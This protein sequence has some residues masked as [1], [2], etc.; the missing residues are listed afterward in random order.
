M[1]HAD[2]FAHCD[3]CNNTE[4]MDG[5]NLQAAKITA[6]N[7]GWFISSVSSRLTL[8]PKCRPTKDAPDLGESSASNSESTP[9]P[10]R[11]I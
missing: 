11:V 5:K 8:C 9:A 6:R 4:W 2:W 7:A 1:W 3:S 10:K